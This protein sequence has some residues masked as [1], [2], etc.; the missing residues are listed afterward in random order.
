MESTTLTPDQLRQR[1]LSNTTE[2]GH[3]RNRMYDLEARAVVILSKRRQ[4]SVR[5]QEEGS[6]V[7][8]SRDEPR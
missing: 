2:D 5:P 1:V 7:W 3:L 4:I 6:D 8:A